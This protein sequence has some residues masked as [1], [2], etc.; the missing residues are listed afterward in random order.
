MK[1]I[2]WYFIS[3]D[4]DRNLMSFICENSIENREYIFEFRLSER[5]EIRIFT[6]ANCNFSFQITDL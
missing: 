1:L 3:F 5:V 2:L 6:V 4:G